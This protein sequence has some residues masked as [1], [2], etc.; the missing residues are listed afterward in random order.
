MN[1]NMF[2]LQEAEQS[3]SGPGRASPKAR[4]W[5]IAVLL[6]AFGLA[7]LQISLIIITMKLQTQRGSIYKTDHINGAT[8]GLRP[9]QL[10]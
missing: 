9:M 2:G 6:V 1:R 10:R 4:F 5:F 3:A 7:A 8:F